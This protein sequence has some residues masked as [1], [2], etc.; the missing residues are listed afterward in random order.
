MSSKIPKL[1]AAYQS[2]I[3]VP[4]QRDLAG[5]QRVIFAV[6]D[7][8]EEL[9]LRASVKEFA[10]A[11]KQAGKRWLLLD[12]T[13]AF[14]EW[15]IGQEYQD[16]YFESPEDLA[17]Y[18]MGELTEFVADYILKLKAHISATADSNTVIALLGVGTL[19][20]LARISTLVDGIRNIVPGRLLVLFP[21][22]YHRQTHTYCLLNAPS[23]W[24]YLAV[25]LLG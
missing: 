4:W 10:L 14:P 23:S 22:E 18:Q 15:M 11:T 25:P 7:R 6:Y 13:S 16:A 2:Y 12:A 21:G 17:G 8:F 19:F 5:E 20:G 9:H 24:N 1:I 3:T